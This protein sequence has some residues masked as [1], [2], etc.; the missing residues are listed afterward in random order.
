MDDHEVVR[1]G[2]KA[3]LEAEDDILV[4]GKRAQ[5]PRCTKS[6][7]RLSLTSWSSM[8]DFPTAVGSSLP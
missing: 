5:P 8:S 7:L 3:L 4:E 6:G 2:V 1:A